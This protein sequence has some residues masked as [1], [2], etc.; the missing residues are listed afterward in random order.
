MDGNYE[1]FN[2]VR[3]SKLPGVAQTV[4][5]AEL[6]A[7]I[8]ALSFIDIN[9]ELHFIVDA[10]YVSGI[11]TQLIESSKSQLRGDGVPSHNCLFGC[12]A[13][14]WSLFLE[15]FSKRTSKVTF[16]WSKSHASAEQLFRG[17][18]CKEYFLGNVVADAFADQAADLHMLLDSVVAPYD[19]TAARL[20]LARTRLF[21]VLQRVQDCDLEET[22]RQRME[23][24][25][26]V[27]DYGAAPVIPQ[28]P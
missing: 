12:N 14:L 16:S 15:S 6:S 11:G 26:H 7:V 28:R 8:D 3:F 10:T 9:V 21:G 23:E 19:W 25:R 24:K 5:R 18:V 4:P 17:H 27:E 20:A 1:A 22:R 2:Y 13:N